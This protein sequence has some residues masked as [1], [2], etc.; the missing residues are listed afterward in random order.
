MTDRAVQ[1]EARLRELAEK[2]GARHWDV[3]WNSPNLILRSDGSGRLMAK[4]FEPYAAEFIVAAARAASQERPQP[5]PPCPICGKDD[6]FIG[7]DGKAGCPHCEVAVILPG[8]AQERPSI[9]VLR[10]ALQQSAERF[11]GLTD[12]PPHLYHVF[13]EC[14]HDYCV[15]ARTALAGVAQ[16]RPSIDV[17]HRK[18]VIE[19]MRDAFGLSREL[20]EDHA[21]AFM[22][23]YVAR[24]AGGSVASPEPS[25]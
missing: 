8:V 24:L 14:P 12:E 21:I 11:H 22:E 3:D 7:R 20:A 16:E 6:L 17:A 2:V 19:A 4:G 9:D 25:E 15:E 13:R 23:S 5:L 18:D 10:E 1:P